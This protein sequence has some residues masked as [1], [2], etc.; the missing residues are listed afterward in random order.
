MRTPK[1]RS[2]V[3]FRDLRQRAVLVRYFD[4]PRTEHWLRITVGTKEQM[5][6]LLARLDKI[7]KED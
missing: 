5:E 3:L 7:L 1:R 2:R 6:V 4:A